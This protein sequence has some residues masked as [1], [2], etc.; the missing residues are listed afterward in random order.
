MSRMRG[1][2]GFDKLWERRTTIA[3]VQGMQI[4]LLG[5]PDLIAAKKTQR[6]KDW[7]QIRR[8]VESDYAASAENPPEDRV[9][10]WLKEARSPAL[11]C[12]LYRRFPDLCNE[13][14]AQRPL[15]KLVPNENED[16]IQTALDEEEKKE[17][18]TDRQYWNPLR[19]ELEDFRHAVG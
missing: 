11:L 16:S 18:E 7:P 4:E 3:L 13:V 2:A 6:D 1:V 9:R 17:R 19:K 10:L 5:L 8:L 12:D 14:A 15:L